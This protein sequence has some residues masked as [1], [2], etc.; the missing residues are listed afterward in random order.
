MSSEEEVEVF[1]EQSFTRTQETANYERSH[2]SREW[3]AI[4]DECVSGGAMTDDC[5][6][7]AASNGTGQLNIV[8]KRLSCG[9]W[10][11][12][13]DSDEIPI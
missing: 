6:I 13:V 3:Q 10:L 5:D 1:A 4:R 11:I 8:A 2:A 12:P 7:V 9:C